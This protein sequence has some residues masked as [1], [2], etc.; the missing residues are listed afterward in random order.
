VPHDS[1]TGQLLLQLTRSELSAGNAEQALG[2]G[3][4]ARAMLQ[5]AGDLR[6]LASAL[7]IMGGVHEELGNLDEAA[8]ALREGLQL[9]ER[10]GNAEELAACLINLGLVEMRRDRIEDAIAC[11]R[12]AIA[13]FERIGHEP[14]K[15]IGYANLGEKLMLR[16]D[17]AAAEQATVEGLNLA[18]AL[19]DLF[20]IGDATLTLAGIALRSGNPESAA[21]RAEEA[22]Q[23]ATLHHLPQIAERAFPLAASAWRAAGEEERARA[24]ELAAAGAAAI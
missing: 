21:T 22:G 19:D 24:A 6:S 17:L 16:G 2:D 7:R 20:T 8:I 13:E 18:R 15:A 11:D 10:V 5:D 4:R 9:A 14:G 3:K 12:R 1:L 23:L